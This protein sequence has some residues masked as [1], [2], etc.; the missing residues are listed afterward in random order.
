M[1]PKIPSVGVPCRAHVGR[2]S[3]SLTGAQG[4][5]TDTSKVPA[6]R[7][8]TRTLPT[9]PLSPELCG[10]KRCPS[11]PRIEV[12]GHRHNYALDM[13]RGLAGE[14][15]E[16]HL[17]A[18]LLGLKITDGL[19]RWEPKNDALAILAGHGT[20]LY[21]LHLGFALGGRAAEETFGGVHGVGHVGAGLLVSSAAHE[22]AN[23]WRAAPFLLRTGCLAILFHLPRLSAVLGD[24]LPSPLPPPFSLPLF[25]PPP[26]ILKQK[27]DGR[28]CEALASAV[29][30]HAGRAAG[31]R[32]DGGI[33]L[34]PPAAPGTEPERE[35]G[36]E[37]PARQ[38]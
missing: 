16:Q 13:I 38:A 15:L 2:F 17:C 30:Q 9:A 5:R 19:Q 4:T 6:P 1:Q 32:G 35:R 34:P 18:D 11:L 28:W 21:T 8:K 23:G 31:E 22:D 36:G 24:S 12:G 33:C 26:L 20:K 7:S 14:F 29:E 37:S 10:C 27:T 3:P 25:L